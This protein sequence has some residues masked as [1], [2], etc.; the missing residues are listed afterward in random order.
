[1][2][3]IINVITVLIEDRVVKVLYFINH[4]NQVVLRV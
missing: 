4:C 3:Y 1:M 2:N